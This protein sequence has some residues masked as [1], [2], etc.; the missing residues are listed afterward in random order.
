MSKV[1]KIMEGAR[2]TGKGTMEMWVHFATEEE[3]AEA[4]AWMK[5]KRNVKNLT[6]M[7]P[8]EAERRRA[9]KKAEIAKRYG[10]SEK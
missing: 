6:P 8:D 3:V 7:T 4:K 5:G 10:I 2:E 1:A 9:E